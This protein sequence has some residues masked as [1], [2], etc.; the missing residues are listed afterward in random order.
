VSVEIAADPGR[1]PARVMITRVGLL[2]ALIAAATVG[3]V[4]VLANQHSRPRESFSW[5]VAHPAPALWQKF[6]L[7]D[8]TGTLA[9]PP[10][11]VRLPADPGT[12]AVGLPAGTGDL[13]YLDATPHQGDETLPGWAAFRIAHLRDDDT[14]AATLDAHAEHLTFVGGTG[15]C[16]LD[17]YVTR[18]G[19]HHYRE[20]ACL[21]QGAHGG[22]VIVAATPAA[23][24]DHYR[25]LLQQAVSAYSSP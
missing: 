24:W 2:A 23:D 9:A 1:R 21:V 20:I 25:P 19:A 14:A 17:D 11:L 12:V 3:T 8:G 16:V 18:V 13:I 6:T 5:F 22:S 15:S 4:L 10:S 7:P